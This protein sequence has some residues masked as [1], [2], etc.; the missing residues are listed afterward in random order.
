MKDPRVQG[1]CMKL[2]PKEHDRLFFP[3]RGATGVAAEAKAICQ[4][5]SVKPEC[6]EYAILTKPQ[7]IWGGSSY[8][9]RA[10]IRRERKLAR[11]SSQPNQ[12]ETNE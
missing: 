9:E 12:G 10:A 2:S 3:E 4:E 6:L 11:N 5:C 7:G 1:D 8:T